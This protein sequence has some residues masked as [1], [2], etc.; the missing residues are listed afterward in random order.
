MSVVERDDVPRCCYEL[1]HTTLPTDIFI[2]RG[3]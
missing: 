3:Q 2:L 1:G